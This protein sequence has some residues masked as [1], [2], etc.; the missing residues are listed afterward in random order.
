MGVVGLGTRVSTRRLG[1]RLAIADDRLSPQLAEVGGQ[2][3]SNLDMDDD[4]FAWEE[5]S[6]EIL[7]GYT[8][9]RC[10]MPTDGK[11]IRVSRGSGLGHSAADDDVA[12]TSIFFV[13][14]E[15]YGSVLFDQPLFAGTEGS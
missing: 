8:C 11:P 4:P 2:P 3:L 15:G 12:W 13:N 5:G 10:V 14:D 1:S 6:R 7:R 9:I